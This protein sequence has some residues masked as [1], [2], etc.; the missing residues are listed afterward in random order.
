MGVSL[1]G[2]LKMH[3]EGEVMDALRALRSRVTGHLGLMPVPDDKLHITLAHQS[4][5]KALKGVSLPEISHP[6]TLGDVHV[7]ERAAA[8]DIPARRSAFV[9]VNEQDQLNDYIS[10]LGL[11]NEGRTFHISLGNLTGNPMDSVGHTLDMPI[12]QGSTR[13]EL[14]PQVIKESR[15]KLGEYYFLEGVNSAL[16]DFGLRS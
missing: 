15:Y 5:T 6:I 1:S 7:V 4:N 16:I 14:P 2:I 3:P 10:K 13:I 12:M 11:P 9:L 8:G